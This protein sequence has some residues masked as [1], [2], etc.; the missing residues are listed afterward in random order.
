M[1]VP[2]QNS[3]CFRSGASS[4]FGSVVIQVMMLVWIKI[5]TIIM[6]QGGE[7]QDPI[8]TPPPQHLTIPSH[9]GREKKILSKE[10]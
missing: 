10:T 7:S 3:N 1:M 5:L 2:K 8:L 6:W 4:F 9:S